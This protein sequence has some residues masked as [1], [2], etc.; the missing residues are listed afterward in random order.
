MLQ[1]MRQFLAVVAVHSLIALGW[2]SSP[3][4][5]RA[6]APRAVNGTCETGSEQPKKPEKA[7]VAKES[8]WTWGYFF[9]APDKASVQGLAGERK[10]S[11]SLYKV[12]SVVAIRGKPGV[13]IK[14]GSTIVRVE[15][16]SRLPAIADAKAPKL[17][18]HGVPQH[19]EY[20]S[21]AQRDDLNKRSRAELPPSKDTVA[22]VIPIRK[23]AAWRALPQ[24][25]RQAHFQKKGD[26]IGHTAIGAKY[27]ER[28]YRKLYHTRYAVETTDHDFITYF[29]FERAHTDDFKSLLK[30]LRDP[31]QNPE[32]NFVDR[33]YE[34]W[35]T[36]IE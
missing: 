3:E 18:F 36:K 13:E 22:V 27:V 1:R 5:S 31:Q 7:S 35:T 34:I 6:D 29:E 16:A 23:S 26:T 19:L 4:P 2:N 21:R 33:E 15:T 24:D 17:L 8:A 20:T 25:E 12:E 10:Q 28:I 11:L 9:A 30:Q 14:P 32:W